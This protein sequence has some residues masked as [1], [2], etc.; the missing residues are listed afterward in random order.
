MPAEPTET[1]ERDDA[2]DELLHD[3]EHADGGAHFALRFAHDEAAARRLTLRCDRLIAE[4]H[5]RDP[6]HAA[7][8]WA[9]TDLSAARIADVLATLT[10]E[11]PHAR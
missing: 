9:E 2:V 8:A 10:R 5:G 6:A 4:A 11:V 1:Q 7:P 3:A